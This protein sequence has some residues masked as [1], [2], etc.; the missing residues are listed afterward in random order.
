MFF[1]GIYA[2]LVSFI[3]VKLHVRVPTWSS[4][5]D[6]R[7]DSQDARESHGLSSLGQRQ[8]SFPHPSSMNSELLTAFQW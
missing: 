6:K 4:P 5:L 2:A 8:I 1:L 3:L 7:E